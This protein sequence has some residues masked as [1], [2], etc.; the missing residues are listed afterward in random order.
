MM[1]VFPPK[2]F[3][4]NGW[5]DLLQSVEGLQVLTFASS[6]SWTPNSIQQ[7]EMSMASFR[8]ILHITLVGSPDLPFLSADI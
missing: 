4:P 6:K 3:F 5:W 8:G 7:G 2:V 1:G